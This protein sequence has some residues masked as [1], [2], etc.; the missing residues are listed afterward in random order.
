MTS[1]W[2]INRK[3]GERIKSEAPF[4]VNERGKWAIICG[5][6]LRGRDIQPLYDT[7][8]AAETEARRNGWLPDAY[9][10]RI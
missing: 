2:H 8:E 10:M 3:E 7:Q 1:Q 5:G 9:I 4:E 6:R